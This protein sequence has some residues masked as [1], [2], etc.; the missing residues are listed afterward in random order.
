MRL[1]LH[2]KRRAEVRIGRGLY[3][4][5]TAQRTQQMAACSPDGLGHDPRVLGARGCDHTGANQVA[6]RNI[7]CKRTCIVGDRLPQLLGR[8]LAALVR[9]QSNRDFGHTAGPNGH[10]VVCDDRR[11]TVLGQVGRV[12]VDLNS[13]SKSPSEIGRVGREFD[14]HRLPGTEI[15]H[16]RSAE[17][18]GLTVG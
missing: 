9:V 7:G 3:A 15:V 11:K 14:L 17:L 4:A 10:T 16:H 8:R 13:V 2:V 12:Y 1:E 5:A 18:V 6:G